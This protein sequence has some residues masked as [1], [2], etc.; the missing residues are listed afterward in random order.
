MNNRNFKFEEDTFSKN[1]QSRSKSYH[2]VLMLL[3]FLRTK[4][5]VENLI[6]KYYDLCYTVMKNR[7]DKEHVKNNYEDNE[8][9][10]INFNDIITPN[11]SIGIRPRETNLK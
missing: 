11:L 3:K 6:F 7:N 8:N 5:Q 9:D 2:E 1:A 4:P 10:F